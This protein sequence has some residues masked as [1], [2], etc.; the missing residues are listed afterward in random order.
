[1]KYTL[2]NEV[3]TAIGLLS[4]KELQ[5]W[6]SSVKFVVKL[7]DTL[8]VQVD[9]RALYQEAGKFYYATCAE[10]YTHFLPLT[11]SDVHFFGKGARGDLA[12]QFFRD[13][14]GLLGITDF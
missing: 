4:G 12:F 11:R 8:T 10:D 9:C 3:E 5:R 14:G 13:F 6:G 1:M 7:S 2:K